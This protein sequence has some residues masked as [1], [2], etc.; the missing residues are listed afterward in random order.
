MIV[1]EKFVFIHLPKTGGTFAQKMIQDSY[2]GL[3]LTDYFKKMLGVIQCK[4]LVLKSKRRNRF[5][6]VGQHGGANHIPAKHQS[7]D[8][9]SIMRNPFTR[10][11]SQYEFRWWQ[12]HPDITPEYSYAD[13]PGFPDLTFKEFHDHFQKVVELLNGNPIPIPIGYQTFQF[14]TF[15]FKNPANVFSKIN[16]DYIISG[17]YHQDMHD[18]EFIHT[19]D[20]NNELYGLLERYGFEEYRI[21]NIVGARKVFPTQGGKDDDHDLTKYYTKEMVQQ[22]LQQDE[23]IFEHFPI[24]KDRVNSLIEKL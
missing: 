14:I 7:K 8:I 1:T 20:L 15:Y 22:V 13:V 10:Y 16:R 4:K 2:R 19:E 11:V 17:E 6:K 3:N 9:V 24:Y 23:L 5:R 21:K 12:S 18:V